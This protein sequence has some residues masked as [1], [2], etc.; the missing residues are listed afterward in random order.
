MKVCHVITRMIVGGAQENTLFS[1]RGL[2]ESGH[3]CVLVTGP[4]PGPE[5]ELLEKEGANEYDVVVCP[6]LVREISP[7]DDF[8][9]Y[10]YLKKYFRE[11]NFDVV[12]THSSKAGIIGRFAAR[13]AGIPVV[14]HTIHGLAFGRYVSAI[15]NFLYITLEKMAAKR[16]DKIFAV[17]KAMIDQSLE[18]GIG[19]PDLYK[20]VYSGMRL[21]LFLNAV[22]DES[23]R[24]N[25][26]IPDD[27]VVLGTVARL[28]KMK[29]YEE[30]FAL[31]PRLFEQFPKLHF[32]IVG[33]GNMRDELEKIALEGG[34]R[35]KISFAGLVAP[36][37]VAKYTAQ[38]DMLAHF[39]L[40]EGLPRAAVQA[41]ACAKPVAAYAL[42]GTP[43]VV[44]DGVTGRLAVPENS[45]SAFHAVCDLLADPELRKK[46]GE[47]GREL[48]KERFAWKTMSDILID[49]YEK[50]LA[51]K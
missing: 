19:T 31:A 12:H 17:A 35:D 6:N 2:K 30:L 15:K 22:K 13:A 34:F 28:F 16:S 3:E 45:E 44:I 50:L 38:M 40:R 36:D 10:L 27:A 25:L 47:A 51:A 41:L 18:A 43:E 11:N 32:L 4:S 5:G 21:E 23:L 48:V 1:M 46:M 39:S 9:A 33:D 14:V 26:C 29:G 20:V 37:D 7:L 8:K 24:K 42:D 49:E